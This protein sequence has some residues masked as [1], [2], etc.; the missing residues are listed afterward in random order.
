MS[1]LTL[2]LA[3]KVADPEGITPHSIL[4]FKAKPLVVVRRAL[5]T[6]GIPFEPLLRLG[7]K[8]GIYLAPVTADGWEL[9]RR[10]RP[11]IGPDDPLPTATVIDHWRESILTTRMERA[12][13][14]EEGG[15][16]VGSKRST[17]WIIFDTS[18]K[19]E[20]YADVHKLLALPKGSILRYD[21]RRKYLT[22]SAED[23][24]F[25]PGLQP[26]RLLLAYAQSA[27]FQRG[28]EPPSGQIPDDI[29]FIPTRL[30][31]LVLV[32]T[33]GDD[34]AYFDISVEGYPDPRNPAFA[35][36]MSSLASAGETPYRKWVAL[37]DLTNEYASLDGTARNEYWERIVEG[38]ATAP[39]QF[40]GDT[41]WRL[42]LPARPSE[43][44]QTV[45]EDLIDD[46]GNTYQVVSRFKLYQGHDL[47]LPFVSHTPIGSAGG[48]DERK[49]AS[50]TS[51]SKKLE[52]VGT[53]QIDLR[54]YS[55][56]TARIRALQ[57]DDASATNEVISFSTIGGASQWP[58]GPSFELAFLVSKRPWRLVI[59]LTL[60][61]LAAVSGALALVSGDEAKVA[62][63]VVA[64][65][66]AFLGTPI[67]MGK[68]KI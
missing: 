9:L 66:L 38:L 54:R 7:R 44:R 25:G 5:K 1:P 39:M 28:H 34:T 50:L 27:A 43:S 3:R 31:R 24:V 57:T 63:T 52:V 64:A 16:H 6:L 35:T 48:A 61:G 42:G 68:L 4:G 60:L 15:T 58:T 18:T 20:Y 22:D 37:S 49:F 14:E 2:Q 47:L 53:G 55:Q 26:D 33:T 13:A 65:L 46:S 12:L 40:E 59:G 29:V 10:G 8:R 11:R 51:H 30:A 36:I 56:D 32:P 19:P 41:F 62:F 17:F 23:A 21:Y 67:L 45:T